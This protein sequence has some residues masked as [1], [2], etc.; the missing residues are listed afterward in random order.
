MD[1]TWEGLK[2]QG[3]SLQD[4]PQGTSQS[5]GIMGKSQSYLDFGEQTS[6]LAEY[7]KGLEKIPERCGNDRRVHP[8]KYM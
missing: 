7:L 8:W 6:R 1:S 3:V 2:F 5:H 4:L